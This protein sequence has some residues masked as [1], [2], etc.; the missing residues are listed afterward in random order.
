MD[1][2]LFFTTISYQTRQLCMIK[3][4]TKAPHDAAKENT[5]ISTTSRESSKCN[6]EEVENAAFVKGLKNVLSTSRATMTPRGKNIAGC[7]I[8]SFT[9][10]HWNGKYC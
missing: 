8:Y 7:C 9:C 1:T 5:T 4:T 2:H 10:L 6:K 3:Y